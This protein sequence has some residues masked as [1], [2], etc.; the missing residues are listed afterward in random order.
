MSRRQGSTAA[1]RAETGD[2]HR[3]AGRHGLP[4]QPMG[5]WPIGG[6][7]SRDVSCQAGVDKGAGGT[8]WP[9]EEEDGGVSGANYGSDVVRHPL[10]D[11][12]GADLAQ[13]RQIGPHQ[14]LCLGPEDGHLVVGLR[15]P[16]NLLGGGAA[17]LDLGHRC[18]RPASGSGTRPQRIALTTASS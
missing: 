9:V 15:S 17:R 6:Y 11:A 16:G 3:P 14:A 10:E 2:P 5:L 4:E 13:Q 12:A 1:G 7:R 8:I 18:Q